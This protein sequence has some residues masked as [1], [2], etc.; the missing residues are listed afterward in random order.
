MSRFANGHEQ[1]QRLFGRFEAAGGVESRRELKP[2]FVSSGRFRCLRDFLQGDQTGTRSRF[3]ALQAGGNQN[4]VFA[5]E[6]D[7]VGDRAEC[8]QIQQR[9]QIKIGEFRQ[10]H[11][12]SVFH[13]GMGEF[14]RKTGGAEFG[15]RR[16]DV[17]SQRSGLVER[18]D[19]CCRGG[20]GI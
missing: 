3:Q 5:G 18:I 10:T 13:Q 20:R 6:R 11:F 8:D 16:S 4:A 2:D 15:K 14:E 9:P 19:Q 7:D 17:G 12:A 1:V